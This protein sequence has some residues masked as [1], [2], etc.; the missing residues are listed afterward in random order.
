[1]RRVPSAAWNSRTS[2]TRCSLRCSPTSRSPMMLRSSASSVS[3]P[4]TGKT[5]ESKVSNDHATSLTRRSPRALG[6][7]PP[8]VPSPRLRARRQVAGCEVGPSGGG[9]DYAH[10]SGASYGCGRSRHGRVCS[11]TAHLIRGGQS[12][13]GASSR[14]GKG[15]R[16]TAEPVRPNGLSALK[17]RRL[18]PRGAPTPST[19]SKRLRSGL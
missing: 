8:T 19:T 10:K 12:R 14:R 3:P 11:A 7:R 5:G 2:A 13:K 15:R 18:P 4:V 16:S 1:M 9:G 17:C 6:R